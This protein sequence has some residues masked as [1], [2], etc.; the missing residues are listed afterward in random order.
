ME[1]IDCV[2]YINLEHRKD[3][4]E[5]FLN[6]MKKYDIPDSKLHRIAATYVKTFGALGCAHS[7]IQV[8]KL[9][10]ASS[11][12]HCIIFEDDF[13]FTMEKSY[14]FDILQEIFSKKIVF[15]VV[16]LAGNILVQ[17][18]SPYPFL[19]RVTEA[20]TTSGYL[21]TKDFAK[22]LLKNFQEALYLLNEYYTQ[23]GTR[24]KNF[25]IDQHWKALQQRYLWYSLFPKAGLQRES[26]SDIEEKITNYGV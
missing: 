19:K 4:K 22:H 14:F 24:V 21:V 15:D 18:E 1:H 20:Q 2:Y 13:E 16:L 23:H 7:H 10:L 17:K 11:H 3:R 12:N 8:L 5:E 6:E 25:S 26:Y 9:F